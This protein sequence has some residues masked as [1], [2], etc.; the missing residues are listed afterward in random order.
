MCFS[1]W[2][3]QRFLKK[4][5][6][7]NNRCYWSREIHSWVCYAIDYAA[8]GTRDWSA[9]RMNLREHME[10][11]RDIREPEIVVLQAPMDAEPFRILC[12][13]NYHALEI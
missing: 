4:Q 6:E 3:K 7:F 5:K 10:F 2:S 11:M 8:I 12:R 1:S 9:I 13:Y